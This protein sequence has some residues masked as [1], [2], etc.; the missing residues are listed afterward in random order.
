[1]AIIMSI[2][3]VESESNQETEIKNNIDEYPGFNIYEKI[4]ILKYENYYENYNSPYNK[5]SSFN[6]N[7][8][9][10]PRK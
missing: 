6:P 4:L 7:G 9:M 1:M 5:I 3:I 2:V 10:I 8:I